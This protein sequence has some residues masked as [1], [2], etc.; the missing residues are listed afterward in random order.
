MKN[1]GYDRK[2]RYRL[3]PVERAAIERLLVVANR[4]TGQ[5]RRVADILLA[6]WNG[7][8]CGHMDI[9][10]FWNLDDSILRDVVTV[11]LLVA[12][13]R[14]HYPNDLGYGNEFRQILDFWRPEL[15]PDDEK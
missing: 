11:L 6:W 7:Q 15:V 4:D 13:M 9:S 2:D 10:H 1:Y 12:R 5:S 3:P 14:A 8:T